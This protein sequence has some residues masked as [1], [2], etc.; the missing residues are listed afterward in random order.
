M[1]TKI[2]T[3][4]AAL[5]ALAALSATAFAA[6]RFTVRVPG[7]TEGGRFAPAQIYAG[8][9]CTGGNRS[10]A[11]VWSNPPAATKSFAVTIFDPDAPTGSGWWHWT[12]F[13]LPASLRALPQGAGDAKHPH[14]PAGAIQGRSDFGAAGYGGPCPP[15]GDRAHHYI[16]TVWALDVDRVPLDAHASGA[17]VG[18]MLNQHARAK[19]LFTLRYGRPKSAR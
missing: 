11:L 18:F 15:A 4:A 1:R 10:P 12:V 16:I 14:L 9:G 13:N 3:I 5:M 8:F 17:M 19:A 2:P 7:A 6:S